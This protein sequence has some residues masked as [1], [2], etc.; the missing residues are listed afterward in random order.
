[1]NNNNDFD[2]NLCHAKL[3][4]IRTDAIN[5]GLIRDAVVEEA[6]KNCE[7]CYQELRGPCAWR[8]TQL[9]RCALAFDKRLTARECGECAKY[10]V[11]VKFVAYVECVEKNFDENLHKCPIYVTFMQT[12]MDASP[13]ANEA[14][15]MTKCFN[16]WR[17]RRPTCEVKYSV[18]LL[19]MRSVFKY[20]TNV[21]VTTQDEKSS[22]RQCVIATQEVYKYNLF[23]TRSIAKQMGEYRQ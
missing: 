7:Y 16:Q 12:N 17:I 14:K 9:Y 2:V 1:M 15:K 21:L 22:L 4:K 20:K 19:L 18:V 5:Y 23:W 6:A 13:C 10:Y 3:D 11:C 8:F